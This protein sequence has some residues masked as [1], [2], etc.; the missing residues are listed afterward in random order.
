MGYIN[1]DIENLFSSILGPWFTA[2]T[3]FISLSPRSGCLSG[4][5]NRIS[6]YTYV[7]VIVT[8]PSID[9]EY[10]E[11]DTESVMLA[12]KFFISPSH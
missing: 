12:G 7:E 10:Q 5:V 11:G 2:N 9:Q 8:I 4:S 1:L 3:L 6:I